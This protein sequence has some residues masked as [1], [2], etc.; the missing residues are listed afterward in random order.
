MFSGGTVQTIEQAEQE[1]LEG[2]DDERFANLVAETNGKVVGSAIG[3][4]LGV[5]SS[6]QSLARLDNAGFLG[7]AAVFPSFRGT[8]VGRALGEAVIGWCEEQTFDSVVTDWRVTNL[9][10]S[11]AWP[12]LGFETTFLRLARTIGQAG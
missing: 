1:W 7:F 3:C 9:L 11:R 8:G 4:S 5:S 2:I 12:S 6:H 10:S